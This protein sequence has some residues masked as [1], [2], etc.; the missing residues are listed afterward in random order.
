MR[1]QG[2]GATRPLLDP[3]MAAPGKRAITGKVMIA[4]RLVQIDKLLARRVRPVERNEIGRH[5]FY[6]AGFAEEWN[7]GLRT[8]GQTGVFHRRNQPLIPTP[9][10]NKAVAVRR[11]T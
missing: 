2:L 9:A 8:R 11:S 4:L 7:G 10:G 3:L 6:I 1:Q 5:C